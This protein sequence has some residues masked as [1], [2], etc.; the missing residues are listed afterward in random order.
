MSL[1]TSVDDIAQLLLL[2]E[3][4]YFQVELLL[5]ACSVNIAQILG[6]N[7]VEDKSSHSSV[8]NLGYC[9]VTDLTCDP[10]LDSCVESNIVVII[11]HDSLVDISEH[12]ALTGFACL[13]E[14][15]VV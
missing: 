4:V 1:Y 14:S 11:S 15:Q 9:L 10:Y 7:G 5:G 12:L 8:D 3:E 13:L 2:Y 6:D